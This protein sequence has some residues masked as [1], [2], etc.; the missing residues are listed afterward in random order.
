MTTNK[1]LR[2][3]GYKYKIEYLDPTDKLAMRTKIWYFKTYNG[4]KARQQDLMIFWRDNE[5]S[6]P[7]TRIR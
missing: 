7:I 1:Q 4:A 2:Q 5:R 3:A 6:I